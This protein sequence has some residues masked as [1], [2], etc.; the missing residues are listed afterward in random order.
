[1]AADRSAIVKAFGDISAKV[2]ARTKSY[3]LLSYCSPS[4]A[5]RHEVRIQAEIKNAQ[6][7][8]ERVGNLR[9]DF[10]ATGFAPGCDPNTPPSFDVTRGD[11]L[12]PPPDKPKKD[13]KDEKT[14]KRASRPRPAAPAAAPAPAA[15]PPASPPPPQP[16]P[17]PP[18]APAP[19]P[20]QD[21]N[22]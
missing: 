7:G 21:F 8:S 6:D 10:D 18:P 12:A 20:S 1:M 9:S 17:P 15:P 3:Y 2:D 14:E 19:K 4:R 16:P 5:G 22:P 13:D 11:L